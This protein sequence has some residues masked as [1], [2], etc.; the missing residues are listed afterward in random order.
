M[1]SVYNPTNQYEDA[2]RSSNIG[3]VEDADAGPNGF[4]ENF[5]VRLI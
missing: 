4:P 3:D 5:R 2:L 1:G